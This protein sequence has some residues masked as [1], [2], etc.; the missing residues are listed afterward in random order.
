[1]SSWRIFHQTVIFG[2]L[3]AMLVTH[4]LGLYRHSHVPQ[5]TLDVA[6]HT[7]EAEFHIESFLT[8]F[9]TNVTDHDDAIWVE[10]ELGGS[11]IAKKTVGWVV[12][13]IFSLAILFILKWI[14]LTTGSAVNK[15]RSNTNRPKKLHFY[16]S[17]PLR[18]PPQ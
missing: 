2:L 8:E 4:G 18:A 11:A 13:A 6:T 3:L 15:H 1:M 7:H 10:I 17:P 9:V 16:L 5:G 14:V 12:L